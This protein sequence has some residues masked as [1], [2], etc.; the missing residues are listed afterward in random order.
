MKYG[1]I[2]DEEFFRWLERERPAILARDP[3]ALV[4]C[5]ARSCQLKAEVVAGD[6]REETGLRAV[7]NFGHTVG[8]AIESVAGYLGKYRHGEAVAIG[9]VAECRL[10]ERLGWIDGEM[11]R[12]VAALLEGF[13]L[14]TSSP[15]LPAD[16]L[17][18]AM[19]RD[20]KNLGRRVRFVLPRRL[21]DVELTDSADDAA[22]LGA[23]T[24]M[25]DGG[26]P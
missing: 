11:T 9:M 23:L 15:E 7:L 19:S 25:P 5:I 17:L 16:R 6:E 2:R 14:P 22:I 10:A 8:H 12:R 26:R 18:E 4:H 1:V 21:G 20:K 13:G 3:A 24:S